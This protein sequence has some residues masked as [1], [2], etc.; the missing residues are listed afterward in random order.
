MEINIRKLF[1]EA[2][3]PVYSSDGANCFDFFAPFSGAIGAFGSVVVNTGVAFDIPADYCLLLFSRS[4][5]G[6]KNDVRLSNCVGVVDSDF[7][8]PVQVKLRNDSEQGFW[9]EAGDRI[10]QGLLVHTPKI[11][12]SEV[13]FFAKQTERGENGFGSTGN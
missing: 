13:A 1:H 2:R 12:F 4:G 10:A 7:T 5:H 3:I 6:F 9:F 8:G 11:K